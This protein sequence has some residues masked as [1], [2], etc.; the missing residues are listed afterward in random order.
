[1]KLIIILEKSVENPEQ[2]EALFSVVRERLSDNPDVEISGR[3]VED[4]VIE[5]P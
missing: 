3:V 1:M 5:E 2:G 4:F